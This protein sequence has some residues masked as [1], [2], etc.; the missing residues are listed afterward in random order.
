[1][2]LNLIAW[3]FFYSTD[4][5]QKGYVLGVPEARTEIPAPER[6]LSSPALS[7]MRAIMHSAFLW[8]SCH[9]QDKIPELATVVKQLHAIPEYLPEFFWGH[10]C[11]DIEQ[12]S[13]VTGKGLEESALVVHHVLHNIFTMEPPSCKDVVSYHVENQH[14]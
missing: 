9:D 13:R 8:C 11:K 4:T 3:C 12:L 5:T 14:V 6:N 2:Y 7:I 1:M 10:L